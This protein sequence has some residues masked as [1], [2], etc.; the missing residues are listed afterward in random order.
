MMLLI[1]VDAHSKWIEA[2]PTRNARTEAIIAALC[3][4]FAAQGLLELLVSGNGI[5]FTALE[6]R[7]FCDM[8][9]IRHLRIPPY[10]PASKWVSRKSS[11]N[12]KIGNKQ[13]TEN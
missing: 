1:V 7:T 12:C 8:N 9:G 11:C 13:T 2:I 4:L 5:P 3:F 10:H 6:L